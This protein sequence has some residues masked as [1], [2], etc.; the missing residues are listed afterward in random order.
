MI[1]VL[2]T[3]DL[4]QIVNGKLADLAMLYDELPGAVLYAGD[5]A[6]SPGQGR[7]FRNVLLFQEAPDGTWAALIVA[8]RGRGVL[9]R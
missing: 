1:P 5:A 8:R 9:H 3:T 2:G 7:V 4:A 6:E